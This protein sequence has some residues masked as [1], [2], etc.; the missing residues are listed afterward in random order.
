MKQFLHAIFVTLFIL[1]SGAINAQT[2]KISGRI[3]DENGQAL[4]GANIIIKGAGKGAMS[5]VDGKFSISIAPGKY[6]VVISF[7]GYQKEEWL[8]LEVKANQTTTQNIKL[9]PTVND[10]LNTVVIT[11]Q[12]NRQSNTAIVL[13][14]KNAS[15]VFDGISAEQIRKAPDRT[16]ADVLKRVSGATIQD[17]Q[18]V[19]VRGLPERYNAAYL[20][21]SPLPSSEPDRKAFSFDIFPSALLNDLKVIKTAMPSLPGEFAGGLITVSTRDIPESNFYQINVGTTYNTIS[22]LKPFVKSAGGKTDFLGIDDGKRS[23][24]ANMPTNEEMITTQNAFDKDKLVEV[25]QMMPNNYASKNIKAIPGLSFQFAMGHMADLNKKTSEKSGNKSNFGSVFAITYNSNSTYRE[26]DRSEFDDQNHAMVSY[27][28]KQYSQQVSLGGLWNLALNF[29]RKNGSLSRISLKNMMN[30]NSNDQVVNRSGVDFVKG[31]DIQSYNTLYTQNRLI[32]SQLNGEHVMGKSKIRLDWSAGY[33]NLNRITPDYRTTTYQRS[34]STMPFM[35]P[36][37]NNVQPNIAGRFFSN[38]NDNSYSAAADLTIPVKI[39]S[40]RHQ[41]KTGTMLSF[42]NRNFSA[43]QLGYARYKSSASNI[44]EIS[45]MGI[46]SVFDS[47]NMG[48]EGLLLREVTKLSDTYRS[49]QNTIA[50]YVQLESSFFE[51]KLRFIYGVRAEHYRQ[52]LNTYALADA[53]PI[54]IDTAVLDFLPSI[55]IVYGFHPKMNIR[56]SGSQTVTRPESRELAPFSFYD[57]GLFALVSGNEKLQRTKIT[58]A[59]I[60]F[61]YYP[62]AGQLISISGFYKHFKNPIEKILFPGVNEGRFFTYINVPTAY[63][64]GAELE[65]RFALSSF[66]KNTKSRFMDDFSILGNLAYM[67]SEV[68]LDSVIGVANKRPLQ[69]Q[70]RFI[71]N[72]GLQYNDS[73]HN[74]GISFMTNYVG[75]RIFLVGNEFDPSVW[76][77]PRWLLDLTISKTFIKNKLELKLACKDLLAQRAYFYEDTNQNNKFDKESDNVN[78]SHRFGQQFSFSVGYKF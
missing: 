27:F 75:R 25:A 22:T 29:K 37:S 2:G 31:Y 23:L 18:F 43:R 40:T 72:G 77:N 66:S 48:T 68:N 10:G 21:G 47:R 69:G 56:L 65:F 7:L 45:Q 63:T 50:G 58:N 54:S 76:E 74:F 44:G 24:P 59:D 11:A 33:S 32:S 30:I 1:I 53:S 62:K 34:D 57:F 60:R 39:G 49:E 6:H 20:N 55:N 12:A 8:A 67:I 38:Q 35:I 73:K 46:D 19:I 4:I 78:F 5:D 3:I 41:I 71:F 64:Y 16:T 13:E 15:V 28:D 9:K 61:E 51:N 17:N 70:S 36:F 26:S 14:Q 42:R 52:I